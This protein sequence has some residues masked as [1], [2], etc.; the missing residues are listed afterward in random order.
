MNQIRGLNP[1]GGLFDFNFDYSDRVNDII[2]RRNKG[3]INNANFQNFVQKTREKEMMMELPVRNLNN[4]KRGTL[5]K[6]IQTKFYCPFVQKE[7]RYLIQN[8]LNSTRR[9]K[10]QLAYFFD[11]LFRPVST[12]AD[13][14]IILSS[15]RSIDQVAVIKYSKK[16]PDGDHEM[17][18]E[19][20]FG[21]LLSNLREFIPNFMY[22]YDLVQCRNQPLQTVYK[23]LERR[24]T[25]VAD[26]PKM[27][28]GIDSKDN[29]QNVIVEFISNPS[30]LEDTII[31]EA[32]SV[33]E[34]GRLYAAL[35][36]ALIMSE[37]R[38]KFVH[39]DLH[40][41]NVQVRELPYPMDFNYDILT[42]EGNE[43]APSMKTFT[44]RTRYVPVVI[45]FG[46]CRITDPKTGIN[47]EGDDEGYPFMGF[48]VR[49]L[50][51]PE[52]V[53]PGAGFYPIMDFYKLM[54]FSV[55]SMLHS[56]DPSK[57]FV[58]Y[59]EKYY[60]LI[61][62]IF[63]TVF[64][65]L[66]EETKR[67]HTQSFR[68]D[69]NMASLP[70]L[71]L[72][73]D[74]HKVPF[75]YGW[76]HVLV[77]PDGKVFDDDLSFTLPFFLSKG[78][79]KRGSGSIPPKCP[80]NTREFYFDKETDDFQDDKTLYQRS[81]LSNDGSFN[82]VAVPEGV[83]LFHGGKD[84]VNSNSDIPFEYKPLNLTE[85][86][87]RSVNDLESLHREV[88]KI[89]PPIA[90]YF[91]DYGIAKIQSAAEDSKDLK[92][93]FN[94]ISA[95]KTIRM[96]KL[97]DLSS[98]EN[99][100]KI[101]RDPLFKPVNKALLLIMNGFPISIPVGKK[102]LEL[103]AENLAAHG[104]GGRDVIVQ[105]TKLPEAKIRIL[106]E[107]FLS[108]PDAP[109]KRNYLPLKLYK[110]FPALNLVQYAM[111]KGYQ[112]ISYFL[113][114]K[115]QLVLTKDV[116]KYLKRDF[117][118]FRDWQS[119]D[120]TYLFG[121]IGNLVQEMKKYKTTNINHHAGDL[122]EHSVWSALFMN[123]FFTN[124]DRD[125]LMDKL[126]SQG[127][128]NISVIAAFL[129]DI[130]KIGDMVYIYYD[131]PNHAQKGYEYIQGGSINVE[132]G[133]I[134]LNKLFQQL[135]IDDRGRKI[136]AF[137]IHNHQ[138]IGETILRMRGQPVDDV[139]Q[140]IYTQFIRMM[141]ESDF[142]KD[143]KTQ[144][145][146]QLPIFILLYNLWKTDMMASQPYNQNRMKK[147]TEAMTKRRAASLKGYLN[148]FI[149]EFPF[150]S[151]LPR[152]HPGKN[153]MAEVEGIQKAIYMGVLK[154]IKRSQPDASNEEVKVVA[155][156]SVNEIPIPKKI[157]QFRR[158]DNPNVRPMQSI[159]K[160][161]QM[162]DYKESSPKPPRPEA[163]PLPKKILSPSSKR[164][165]SIKEEQEDKKSVQLMDYTE[166]LERIMR[167]EAKAAR[168][169]AAEEK[170]EQEVIEKMKN[171]IAKGK[172]EQE[173]R[174]MGAARRKEL[175]EKEEDLNRM[176]KVRP[177]DITKYSI[178]SLAKNPNENNSMQT[179]AY[180][181]G[182]NQLE[183][184]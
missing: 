5:Q 67:L 88:D 115:C 3:E 111:L 61:T 37:Q 82:I 69:R 164:N 103:R 4:I 137:L 71:I 165:M 62:G 118:D 110:S 45:D 172:K 179:A 144:P 81:I 143:I 121:E 174:R 74:P 27:C 20:T 85:E 66:H 131:K 96:M 91:G 15:F 183:S 48:P 161:V 44:V 36:L 169:K 114:G 39:H 104:E 63:K 51:L 129:H 120:D 33:D 178:R 162:M 79:M 132:K 124:P 112:G 100:R 107:A 92:C 18:R 101:L 182:N 22:V 177:M 147:F 52:N 21:K 160:P 93:S 126:L 154:L 1:V 49:N 25:Q 150:I 87:L 26:T 31:G 80:S 102:Q 151:N 119:I 133:V 34:M 28:S 170:A 47:Y 59:N 24:W 60:D 29:V 64:P 106:V 77:K 89:S 108:S 42:K 40:N 6:A 83:S 139:N 181:R 70:P 16:G 76:P 134:N 95:Y 2:R 105:L 116:K 94:C 123:S 176:S 86:Q 19:F 7:V 78:Y 175:V 159:E 122:H 149:E 184:L 109:E 141:K 73:G 68:K 9:D 157:I 117:D 130:G 43:A 140:E 171:Y 99:V 8:A 57:Q 54:L 155:P 65:F 156:P 97:L 84:L 53:N 50:G 125:V 113:E 30:S 41:T 167:E 148:E 142:G 10:S 128:K 135:N 13:G 136:I 46:R 173:A 158:K 55:R 163:I 180:Y 166:N 56:L 153:K 35:F 145:S 58:V 12:S 32:L 90:S 152:V 72:E 168:E 11:K 23:P 14:M 75:Y 138:M 127:Y 38:Y 17:Y 146:F 98:G